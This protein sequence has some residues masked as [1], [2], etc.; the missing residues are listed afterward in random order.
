MLIAG[1][2]WNYGCYGDL[3]GHPEENREYP[4]DFGGFPEDIWEYPEKYCAN[5]EENREYP[6][7]FGG[8][9][10]GFW[11][12]PDDFG[13]FPEEWSGLPG[14]FRDLPKRIRGVPEG[15]RKTEEGETEDSGLLESGMETR[16]ARTTTSFATHW[17]AGEAFG[18]LSRADAHALACVK[19]ITLQ[20]FAV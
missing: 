1:S 18:E 7:G 6:E 8:F 4:E 12:H 14:G 5:P 19:T 13:D 16:T 11:G 15:F 2:N 9:P 3:G 17:R 10:V 20:Q